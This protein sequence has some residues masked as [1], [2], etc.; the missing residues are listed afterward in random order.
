M[1]TTPYS[2]CLLIFLSPSL[3]PSPSLFHPPI[4]QSLMSITLKVLLPLLFLSPPLVR[5]L[6]SHPE[7]KLSLTLKVHPI[8]CK[9]QITN[10]V[11][12]K[13]AALYSFPV[14]YCILTLCHCILLSLQRIFCEKS[15]LWAHN[16]QVLENKECEQTKWMCC[17]YF[18]FDIDM[19]LK[20]KNKNLPP[21]ERQFW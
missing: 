16:I 14:I 8:R 13:P 11:F 12:Y 1:V 19:Y 15:D 9:L 7:P 3:P 2:L 4:Y 17:V 10:S 21:K 6:S 18:S 5:T 20:E